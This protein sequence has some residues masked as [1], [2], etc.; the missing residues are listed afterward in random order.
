MTN[1]KKHSEA[2]LVAITFKKT[3]KYTLVS[4]TDNGKG[5]TID[6]KKYGNGLQNVENRISAVQGSFTFTSEMGNGFKAEIKVPY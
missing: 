3:G 4:Y 6:G 2:S 5:I 1:M